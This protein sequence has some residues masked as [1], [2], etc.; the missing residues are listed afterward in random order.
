MSPK[1]GRKWFLTVILSALALGLAAEART[2]G[3]QQAVTQTTREQLAKMEDISAA[4]RAVAEVVR[5]S[6]VSIR[7]RKYPDKI[8]TEDIKG[9]KPSPEQQERDE[10]QERLR[11]FF[12]PIDPDFGDQPHR[13]QIRP[14]RPVSGIGS[15]IIVDA[16]KGYILT[17]YH[18]VREADE[19]QVKLHNGY[20]YAAEEI[21][22]DERADLAIIKI[23]ADNLQ[24]AILGNSEKAKTGDIV[25]AVG[26]PW[27]L[28]Q[29][30][31][32][33]IISAKNRSIG[34]LLGSGIS[35][36]DYIQTDAAVNPGNSGGPL[37]N[38]RGQVI[39]INVAIRPQSG[40]VPA[41]AGVVFAIPIDHAK[42]VMEHI[43]AGKPLKR[44]YLGV[45]FVDLADAES[46]LAKSL[47]SE[48]RP[49]VV[50]GEVLAN[51]PAHKAGLQPGDVILQVDG[52][53]IID[54]AVLQRA[55]AGKLPG[56]KAVLTILRNKKTMKLTVKVG[57]QPSDEELV[58]MRR[59][60]PTQ[61]T[62]QKMGLEVTELTAEEAAQIGVPTQTKGLLVKKVKRGSLGNRLGIRPNDVIVEL[63]RKKV[64]TIEEFDAILKTMS[65]TEGISVTVVNR[66]G[67]RFLY[68]RLPR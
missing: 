52:Q 16:A 58:S 39:G 53:S 61:A 40:M 2:A 3:A 43:I 12:G 46:G 20:R 49:G 54:G 24:E 9:P 34:S 21:G 18:V 42:E 22:Y 55:I 6:V 68:F 38:V 25:L 62:I 8:E 48:H 32:Q 35:D 56:D 47:G 10:F 65:P 26:S 37:V 59:H 27:G 57:E 31:T 33:G 14:Q 60:K 50:L 66:A 19:I 17:N 51:E 67:A 41:Y 45:R 36:A 5:P 23:E 13:R 7:V 11:R 15:G 28:E 4:F 63:Q 29:T 30:V 64:Q 44:G 1:Q